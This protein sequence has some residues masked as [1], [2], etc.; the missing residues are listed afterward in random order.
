MLRKNSQSNRGE[1]GAETQAVLMSAYRTLKPR[2]HAIP[3]DASALRT[4]LTTGTL[5]SLPDPAMAN[6]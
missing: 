4:Y 5:P 3:M 2:G 6:G 1:K